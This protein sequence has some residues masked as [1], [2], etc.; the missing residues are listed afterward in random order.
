MVTPVALRPERSTKVVIVK[1]LYIDMDNVLVDFPSGMAAC[2][3]ALLEQ[4]K[5]SP[6]EIPG[7]SSPSQPAGRVRGD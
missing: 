7:P 2:D 3:P 5:E 1:I 6:D 4:H